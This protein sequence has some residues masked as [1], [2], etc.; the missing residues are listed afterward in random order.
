MTIVVETTTPPCAFVPEVYQDELLHSPP[1][2][3][4]ITAAEWE[5]LTIKRATAHR[6]CAGCP[7][8]RLRFGRGFPGRAP[9]ESGL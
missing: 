2:R 6:Q 3:T 5:T 8:L 1:A 9:L 4:D 7:L